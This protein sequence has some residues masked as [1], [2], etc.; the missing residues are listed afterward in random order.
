MIT[1][2]QKQQTTK[3]L[4]NLVC[5]KQWLNKSYAIFLSLG[6]NIRISTISLS[7]TL[8]M[9]SYVSVAQND[10]LQ[11]QEVE[12]SADRNPQLA[13]ETGRMIVVISDEDIQKAPVQNVQELLNYT[14]SIDVRQRG[15]GGIQADIGI[16]G[17]SFNQTGI[18]INGVRVSDPQTGHH[19]FN[20]PIEIQDIE[21]IEILQGPGAR[22][23]GTGAFNGAVNI[24]TK[25]ALNTEPSV[26][27][28][29]S[30]GM[31]NYLSSGISSAFKTG[32]LAHYLTFNY[33]QSDGYIENSDFDAI[34]AFYRGQFKKIELN[35][36]LNLKNF[37]ASTFYSAKY[38]NQ[39]E[40]TDSYFLNMI[41]RGGE[42]LKYKIRAYQKTH[43]DYF[44]LKR[45]NPTFYQNEHYT[46][47]SGV[48]GN[49]NIQSNFGR[50]SFGLDYRSEIIFGTSLGEVLN[51]SITTPVF[52]KEVNHKKA[53]ANISTFFNHTY[54]TNSYFISMGALF[55]YNDLF[56]KGFYPGME[57]GIYTGENSEIYASVNSSL[58]LPTYTELYTG[59][60]V[61]VGNPNLKPE[62]AITSELGFKYRSKEYDIKAALFYRDGKNIIDWVKKTDTLAWQ[63]SNI[64]E[65]KTLGMELHANW[66]L[67]SDFIKQFGIGFMSLNMN[68]DAGAYISKYALDYLKQK[69]SANISIQLCDYLSLQMNYSYKY[70]LGSYLMYENESYLSYDYKPV[71]LLDAR[72][73]YQKMGFKFYVEALNIFDV[74]Y[75]DIGSVPAPGI[76]VRTGLAYRFKL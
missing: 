49:A 74:Q 70:R 24:I 56:G 69:L 2:K 29:A 47:T 65:L 39:Y 58:R 53:T 51:E 34:N 61:N 76:W 54:K 52:N 37:G 8:I 60:L 42:K 10:T 63:S 64:T 4:N 26:S 57:L 9:L 73:V 50:T 59:S 28:N 15:V 27:L 40:E 38:P 1:I 71:N 35:T 6:K 30:Y 11:I 72:L 22:M 75:H 14:S 23:Y 66:N 44:L 5:F 62:K 3:D 43:S 21:R 31:F 18:F 7:Y 20:I 55:N 32:K 17:G 12:V 25:S 19:N 48:D 41:Y 46:F 16:R 33:K 13:S 45:D 36:G 67:N 68:K